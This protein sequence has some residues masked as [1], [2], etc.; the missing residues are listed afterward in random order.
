[1]GLKMAGGPKDI[2]L[3]YGREP[4]VIYFVQKLKQ[5]LEGRGY[6]FCFRGVACVCFFIVSRTNDVWPARLFVSMVSENLRFAYIT[7]SRSAMSHN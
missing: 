3:S 2:F 4:E 7:M 5:D 6:S 1:M